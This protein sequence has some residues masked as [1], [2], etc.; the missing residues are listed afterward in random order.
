[1]QRPAGSKALVDL[2]VDGALLADYA[3]NNAS[4]KS[5]IGALDVAVVEVPS[6]GAGGK[7]RQDFAHVGLSKIHLVERLNGSKPCRRPA[8]RTPVIAR[9]FVSR[10]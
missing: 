4:Q 7:L 5:E 1:L 6:G 8:E 3:L 10:H 9:W 2:G